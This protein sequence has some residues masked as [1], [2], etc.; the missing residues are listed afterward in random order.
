MNKKIKK[1]DLLNS[2]C[3]IGSRKISNVTI[4]VFSIGFIISYIISLFSIAYLGFLVVFRFFNFLAYVILSLLPFIESIE[5][6]RYKKF[7][8]FTLIGMN[9]VLF[10]ISYKHFYHR[11]IDV[12]IFLCQAASA[13]TFLV[14]SII[15]VLLTLPLSTLTFIFSFYV[16]IGVFFI[17]IPWMYPIPYLFQNRLDIAF[18]ETSK[19]NLLAEILGASNYN[20]Y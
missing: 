15:E 12:I 7:Y 2:I 13:V 11:R 5:G 10:Y 19:L 16:Y 3:I 1:K 20:D 6:N 4:I 14:L 17:I 9:M 18:S 8:F